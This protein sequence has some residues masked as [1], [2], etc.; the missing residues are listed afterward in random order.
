M[1]TPVNFNNELGVG[2]I[3][4]YYKD[5]N[6]FLSIEPVTQLFIL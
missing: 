6:G 2:T 5:P 4:I 3:E 1:L